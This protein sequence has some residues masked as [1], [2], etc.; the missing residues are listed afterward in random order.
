[1]KR[2]LFWMLAI[3]GAIWLW[4]RRG[5][6]RPEPVVDMPTGGDPAGGDTAG[7]PAEELRRKLDETKGRGEGSEKDAAPDPASADTPAEPPSGD[8]PPVPASV[9]E[10]DAKRREVH[11][12]ARA[13]ADEMHR[14]STD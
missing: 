1:M 6:R 5:A 4:L 12:R 14:T 8:A 9:E 7:D 13:A 11:D 2:R 3:G 10:L